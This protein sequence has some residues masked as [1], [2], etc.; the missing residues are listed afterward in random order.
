MS[1]TPSVLVV[2]AG[3]TG[4][5]A[6]VELARRGIRSRVIERREDP[7]PFSRAVGLLKSSLDILQP[8]GAARAIEAEAIAF[9]GITF[10]D[11]TRE[12][13]RLPAGFDDRSRIWGLPQDRTE[14][15]IAEAFARLG[16]SV[17]YGCALEALSQDD[18]GVT[19]TLNGNATRFDCVIGADGVRSTTRKA[20]GLAYPGFDLPG[21][22]SIADIE[23]RDWPDPRHFHGFLLPH[24]DVTIVV[25]LAED[26]YRL[27][28]SRPDAIAA[29]PVP[30]R[31]TR[32]R[33]QGT[34]R[35]SVRQVDSYQRGKVFLA[36][37]AAHCH[38]P[39]GGRGM[40]LGI[41]D[42]ADLAARIAG[43]DTHGYSEA[44]HAAGAAVLRFSETGRRLVQAK[45]PVTR[46]AVR[47][48]MRLAT[49]VPPLGRAAI[50]RMAGS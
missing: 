3:P 9:E 44:R 42:A 14:H 6:A 34:F 32:I 26:R 4:L 30:M 29:L 37:D 2:G 45:G 8:C 25:P 43:G 49:Q 18:H 41:A 48:L 10:S 40:N 47:V 35:I 1:R 5:T 20:L 16:G 21:D 46:A 36:G 13:A 28:S 19:A 31:I 22:W 7:S 11:G 33:R 38:S 50:H 17:D 15:H 24:G 23:A 27:V 39:F 12:I